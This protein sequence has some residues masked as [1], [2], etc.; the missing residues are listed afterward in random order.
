MEPKL[1]SNE[2]LIDDLSQ[3]PPRASNGAA[4]EMIADRVMG[5]VSNGT[6]RREAVRGREAIHLQGDV[7]LENNG[8]FLQIALD[9]APWV[10]HRCAPMDRNRDR[11]HWQHE[12]Y[13]LHLRTADVI[14]PWQSYRQSFVAKP[15]WQTVRLPFAGFKAHRID[16]PLDLRTLRRIG[17]VAIGRAFHADIAI[18]AFASL[19]D[20]AAS[21]AL[22]PSRSTFTSA[23]VRPSPSRIASLPVS[24]CQRSTATST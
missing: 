12:S 7:S 17:I 9:L 3:P 1:G 5:G 16:A 14:R 18:A 8:G 2:Q 22:S 10:L 6:M 11:R 19:A 4:W 21:S 24:A 13:N 20:Q 15:E 23:K